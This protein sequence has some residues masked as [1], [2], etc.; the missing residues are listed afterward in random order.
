MK[1]C[2]ECG[3]VM[4]KTTTAAGQIIFQC[5]CLITEV[6]EPRDTLMY[7]EFLET[8]ESNQ[9]HDVF[10]ENSPFDLAANV[11]LKDCP[12]CKLN[13][14]IMTRIGS[15]EITIYTCSC[16]YRATHSEYMKLFK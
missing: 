4:A 11:V 2:E 5:I 15:D 3:S 13:F 12:Q 14:M 1:F 7:E 10:I 8:A 9:K 16:G 6:G